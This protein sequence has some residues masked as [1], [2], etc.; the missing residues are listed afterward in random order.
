MT[1][2]AL[3]IPSC[4]RPDIL[5][6]AIGSARNQTRPFNDII[7][8]NDGAQ[9]VP[10]SSGVRLLSTLGGEGP[11]RARNFG[12][13]MSSTDYVCYL[14]DDDELMPNYVEEQLR[15]IEGHEFAFSRALFRYADGFE[16]T[17][18]EPGNPGPKR[19]YDPDALLSQNIAPVSS[20]IH[21]RR[22]FDLVGGWD[23]SLQKMEDWDFWGR[24]YI[25]CGTPGKA[26]AVTNIVHR[27]GGPSRGDG[28]PFSYSMACMIRDVVEARL[29]KM[30]EAGEFSL[31]SQYVDK[32]RIPTLGIV[33]IGSMNDLSK[34][35]RELRGSGLH[36][37]EVTLVSDA[38]VPEGARAVVPPL[39]AS[40]T[41]A[42][43]LG[44]L[45]TRTKYVWLTDRQ[46]PRRLAAQLKALEGPGHIFAAGAPDSFVARRTV[47]E[48]VGGLNESLPL[49][50]A[51]R[52]LWS[53]ASDVFPVS[54]LPGRC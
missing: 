50:K 26:D 34:A 3:V 43:N 36:D 18:P 47:I 11:S 21:T 9:P 25:A 35:T 19:Y 48:K 39:G 41:R 42:F 6:R 4:D 38:P 28:S 7:V 32:F 44:L 2:I 16:T 40:D 33:I 17:D 15:A 20:F 22:A 54:V 46:E 8:V 51:R 52:D 24:M 49:D 31:S 29:R 30:G 53:R 23:E 37:F 10:F 45:M 13:K 27:G 14:D 5:Q 1:S 12:V